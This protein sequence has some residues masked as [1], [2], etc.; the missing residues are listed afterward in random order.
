MSSDTIEFSARAVGV[1]DR[2]WIL[3]G[4]AADETNEDTLLF[5][6]RS[7]DKFGV[8]VAGELEDVEIHFVNPSVYARETG[9]IAK[10]ILRRHAVEVCLNDQFAVRHKCRRL[11]VRFQVSA[12]R[13]AEVRAGLA[14]VF[15]GTDRFVDE[16]GTA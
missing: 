5:L 16:V 2:E 8:P 9:V 1:A 13:F 3:V 7:L 14:K 12:Q 6:E 15:A 11:V 10:F 4:F